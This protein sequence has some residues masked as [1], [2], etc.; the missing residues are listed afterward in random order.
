MLFL[1]LTGARPSELRELEWSDIHLERCVIVLTRHKTIRT[2]RRPRP[3]VIHLV[4]AIIKLLI[5]I[6]RRGEGDKHV[7]LTHQGTPWSRNSIQ[8]K[9]RRLRAKAGI[10]DDVKLYGLRHG[11]AT[12]AVLNGLDIKTLAELMGHTTTRVT[13]GYVHLAGRQSHLAAAMQQAIAGRQDT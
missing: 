9:I 6:R 13:E 8:Q 4:P 1:K 12:R 7:F 11:F 3:R 10:P 2:Q 5:L